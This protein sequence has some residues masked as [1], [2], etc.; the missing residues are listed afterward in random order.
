[1]FEVASNPAMRRAIKAAHESRAQTVSQAWNWLFG[2][3]TSR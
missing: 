3:K 1:M 2:N